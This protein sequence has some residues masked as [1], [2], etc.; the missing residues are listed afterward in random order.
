MV[1]MGF[2]QFVPIEEDTKQYTYTHILR[3]YKCKY[4]ASMRCKQ[5][6]RTGD[7]FNTINTRQF[8]NR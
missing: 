5:Q 2:W 3:K 7:T 4:N 8:K 1:A 6:C